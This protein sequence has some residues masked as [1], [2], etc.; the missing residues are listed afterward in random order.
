[1]I[2]VA[3]DCDGVVCNFVQAWL[4]VYARLTGITR[5][6][7]ECTQYE[8][9][10]ALDI[11]PDVSR[12][13][14]EVVSRPGFASSLL[15]Y[16]GAINGVATLAGMKDVEITWVTSP[17]KTSPTWAFEREHW[18]RD[19]FGNVKVISCDSPLKQHIAADVFIDDKVETVGQWA[20]RWPS[21]RAVLWPCPWNQ[22]ERHAIATRS[23]I[24]RGHPLVHPNSNV[25]TI[26]RNGQDDP[27]Y[28]W[29]KPWA[30]DW[31]YLFIKSAIDGSEFECPP[32][33]FELMHSA[34]Q[35]PDHE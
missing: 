1:V 18:L 2:H 21:G 5:W 27:R 19:R 6:A 23:Q 32:T 20:Y 4:D 24:M 16:D 33:L 11:P 26:R 12:R 7:D 14:W 3:I 22:R 35:Q 13:V 25:W 10:K 30:W 31:L 28:G 29:L 9:C 15:A 17:I 8:F 34:E